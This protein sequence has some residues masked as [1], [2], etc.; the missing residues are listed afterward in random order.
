MNNQHLEAVQTYLRR[1]VSDQ[2]WEFQSPPHGTGQESYLA[3]CGDQAFF[4]KLGVNIERHLVM[5]DLGLSPPLVTAGTLFDGTSILV[6]EYVEGRM[7]TRQD[8][9]DHLRTFASHLGVTHQSERLRK[10]LPKRR[11]V[12]YKDV[13]LEAL[14]EVTRRW[15]QHKG[16]VPESV[17]YVDEKIRYLKEVTGQ[18]EGGGLVCS[19]NDPCNGNCL[20]AVDGR[21]YL[22]DYE[23]MALDDPAV[24]L[25]A[26][27]WWYYPLEM[28]MDFIEIA[29]YQDGDAFRER[30][31]IRMAIH[32]LHILLPRPDS[33]DRFRIERFI[34]GLVDF[35]AVV[36]GKEN[37][38]GY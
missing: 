4:V 8:F 37:P 30:M 10:V 31:R 35:R 28:R 5:E 19:H 27:L 36:E 3:R 6:Q 29:G 7:P 15:E 22:L 1:N 33:L 12:L 18:L 17:A 32:C 20:L 11:S 14:E 34:D 38:Q 26:I 9:H 24:D 16:E 13:G 23:S 21:I 2:G 25:G